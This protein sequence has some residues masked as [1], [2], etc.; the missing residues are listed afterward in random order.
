MP[1]I[2]RIFFW[3]SKNNVFTPFL[4]HTKKYWKA[5]FIFIEVFF[6]FQS[7]C[8]FSFF[9]FESKK[10][11]FPFHSTLAHTWTFVTSTSLA[12]KLHTLTHTHM[13][14]HTYPWMT[15]KK[16]NQTERF[17][18]HSPQIVPI[19]LYFKV[20]WIEFEI[21][22]SDY[23]FYHKSW[24]FQFG[25]T[26][27]KNRERWSMDTNVYTKTDN[28]NLIATLRYLAYFEQ[29]KFGNAS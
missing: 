19:F 11:L 9:R 20:S 16:R 2:S 26:R 4:I 28:L 8:I 3:N 27:W 13:H 24:V 18:A 23:K 6:L 1:L 25:Q 29:A 5:S 22:L 14:T 10:S 21:V 17:F 15:L 7:L 12:A